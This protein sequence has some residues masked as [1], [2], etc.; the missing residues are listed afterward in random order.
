M[1]KLLKIF[2]SVIATFFLI[3]VIAAVALPF[4][5]SPNDFKPQI[6]A[7]IKDKTGRELD[8]PGELGLSVF[9][10]LGL[11]TGKIILNNPP[12]FQDKA[13]A[14][15]EK[16]SIKVKLI[17]LLS[18]K[19]EVDRIVLEGL[20]LNLVTNKQGVTNWDD[21]KPAPEKANTATAAKEE[22][23]PATPESLGA[24][25]IAGITLK[26]T[27]ID[28]ND[29]KAGTHILIKALNLDTDNLAFAKPMDVKLDFILENPE[30]KLTESVK[31]ATVL[32]INEKLDR[33]TLNNIDLS[34][35]TQS[36]SIPAGSLNTQINAQAALDLNSQQLKISDLKIHS[37][38]LKISADITGTSIKKNPVFEGSISVAQFNPAQMLTQWNI[39]LPAMRDPGALSRLSADFNLQASPTSADLQNLIIQL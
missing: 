33:F 13:F 14:E 4:F 2:L 23:P 17:P 8:I 27:R 28:W 24:L 38:D 25:A 22:T 35:Q 7:A 36:E 21:L 29:Q 5:V 18:K 3:I 16:S 31:L 39:G 19:I 26:N 30:A 1:G 32:N 9:P 15:V 11:T 20:S 12:G 6:E 10:W 37:G 34:S